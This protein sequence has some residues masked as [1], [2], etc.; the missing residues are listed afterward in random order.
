MCFGPGGQDFG[1]LMAI[2]DQ[3]KPSMT[4]FHLGWDVF[5]FTAKCAFEYGYMW[6]GGWVWLANPL[7]WTGWFV[8][9]LSLHRTADLP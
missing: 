5:V 9:L 4:Q 3:A 8:G 6:F 1:R 2:G 7:F